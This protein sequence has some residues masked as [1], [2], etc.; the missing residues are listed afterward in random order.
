M[1]DHPHLR[2]EYKSNAIGGVIPLGSP[3]LAW[4]I[5]EYITV[6]DNGHRITPTCVGNTFSP[7]CISVNSQG[8]PPLA[9]GI[10][11]VFILNNLIFRITPTCVGN[12]KYVTAD[13][14]LQKD[15]PHLRG[16]YA[17]VVSLNLGKLG[18]PPLAWGIPTGK[19]TRFNDPR[20]T[21]TCVGN[22]VMDPFSDAILKSPEC[23][24]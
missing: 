5:Q 16:E 2:G 15:H 6:K 8:S 4:G 24:F 14:A 7:P 22:T 23:D 12:T 19:I 10:H 9:W 18:S 13:Q 1:R 3:P 21:P 17:N 20:I 11:N